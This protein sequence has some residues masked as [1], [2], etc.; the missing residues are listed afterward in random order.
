MKYNVH[1][2]KKKTSYNLTSLFPVSSGSSEWWH[3]KTKSEKC[4][5]IDNK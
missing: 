1:V 5:L 2:H 3:H 4:Y